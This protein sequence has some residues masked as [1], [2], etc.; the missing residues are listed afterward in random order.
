MK[1]SIELGDGTVPG[2]GIDDKK[3]VRP[4]SGAPDGDIVSPSVMRSVAA[5]LIP[6]WVPVTRSPASTPGFACG[7]RPNGVGTFAGAVE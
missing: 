6:C 2:D 1:P 4:D 3:F 5:E 7:N